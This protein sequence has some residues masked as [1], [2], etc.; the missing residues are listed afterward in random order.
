MVWIE[1]GG[2]RGKGEKKR[3]EKRERG[4]EDVGHSAHPAR[5]SSGGSRIFVD[6]LGGKLNGDSSGIG[7]I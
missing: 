4:R 6:C 7:W 2:G 5:R 3:K 1:G